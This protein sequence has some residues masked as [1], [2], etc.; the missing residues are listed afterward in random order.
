MNLDLFYRVPCIFPLDFGY[1]QCLRGRQNPPGRKN[2]EMLGGQEE[3]EKKLITV[4]Y[5][6]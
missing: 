6:H 1:W 3:H 4:Y 2:H 5:R